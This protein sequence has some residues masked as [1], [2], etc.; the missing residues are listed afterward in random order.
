MNKFK[1]ITKQWL[2][3]IL[4]EISDCKSLQWRSD[5]GT[6]EADSMSFPKGA[7]AQEWDFGLVLF[8]GGLPPLS[9]PKCWVPS[10]RV[11]LASEHVT[12][13]LRKLSH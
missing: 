10:H 6:V 1:K 4:V 2:K 12:S 13:W 5:V 3:E 11:S 8:L 7:T 9:H